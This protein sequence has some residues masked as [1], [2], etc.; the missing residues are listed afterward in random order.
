MNADK[1]KGKMVLVQGSLV[2]A[3]ATHTKG[4]IGV[5]R[6]SSAVPS[7]FWIPAFAGMTSQTIFTLRSGSPSMWQRI[8]SPLTTGPTFSGVP[9]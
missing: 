4:F 5:H 7:L 1:S 8:T 6:R 3:E 9:E 2:A